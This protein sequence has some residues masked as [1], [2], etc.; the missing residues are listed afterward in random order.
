MTL[1]EPEEEPVM[2]SGS[3]WPMVLA[4]GI[5]LTWGLVMTGIWW[6][7]FLGLGVTAF[8]TFSWAFQPAF[9]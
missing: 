6:M 1:A 7:P 9:R 4:F 2:P 8:A 3:I 5:L